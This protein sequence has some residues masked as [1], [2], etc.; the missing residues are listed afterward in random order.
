MSAAALQQEVEQLAVKELR[1]IIDQ[2]L[3]SVTSD[4]RGHQIMAFSL[5]R[6]YLLAL[7]GEEHEKES[8]DYER[9]EV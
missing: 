4:R 3:S 9:V 1:D 5:E 8:S 6:L 7:L 2:G